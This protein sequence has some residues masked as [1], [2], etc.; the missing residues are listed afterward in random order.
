MKLLAFFMLLGF[1]A[2]HATISA[3]EA[4]IDLKM[5]DATLSQVFRNI[6]QLTE[7]MFIYKSEDV[8][9]I[10]HI[11][12]D[13]RQ[14]MVR[15]VL[16]KC[17]ENTGLSFLFKEN[18]IIIQKK[19]TDQ[20][21]KE[22]RIT[23]KVT[24][25]KKEPLPGV[26]VI[27]KGT[28]LG[29]VTDVDGKYTLA[30]P[31][32]NNAL[33]F[34]MI[35]MK[36]KEEVI[37][38]RTQIDVVME[39]EIS[40]L[41]DV[42]VT[43]YYTQAKN[44]FTGA[45][46]T[47]TAEELQM[48]GNQNI[49]TA[50]QNVDP[51]FMKIDNNLAGSNPN[52]VPE[53][54]IRGAGS[55]SGIESEYEGNPNTPVFIVDGFETTAEKVYDMDPYRVASITLLKDAAATAIYGSRASNGVVV[56]TT[57]A[58]ANGKMQVS[59][60]VDASFYIAD[61]SDYN[62]CNAVEKLEIEKLAGMYTS[63]SVNQQLT[64]NKWYNEKL[65]NIERGY[66]TYWL[67]KPL[68]AVAVANKH[69][70]RL[71]GGNDNIRYGIELGYSNTPGVMK[72]SGR[73]RLALGM[74]LQ[75]IYK[76]LTFRNNLTYSNVKAI[77]SPYGSF[78]VYTKRNPYVRYKDDD[79]NYIYKVDEY[80]PIGGG[81]LGKD[82]YNP[83]YNTTLN[84]TDEEKYN[85]VTNNFGVDWSIMDGLR[86][87]GSFS[88]THQNTYK[89][90]FKPAKHTDF[91]D[92]E[93]D[94]FDRRGSYVGSR[95]ENYSYDASLVMTYFY[96]LEKHVINAN[97]GWN[98]QESVT[99]EF[100][101]KTEGFPNENLDYISFATQYEKDG[102]PAGD[103]Y[104]SRLVGFLGNLNYSYDERYLLDLSF[105]EDASSRFGSDKRWAPFWS[106]G[107]GWNLHNEGFLKN[108]TFINRLK[109]RG[110]YG[111]TGS[112][113]YNPY[114]A[115]TTYKYL[116]GERYHHTVG[117]E[118]MALG[119]EKLGWQRTLQQNYGV[120]IDLWDERINFTGNYYI[121]LS[122]DVLTT[123]TLPPSLGFN[124]YMDNLG[125]VK[126][127]GY[128]LNLRVALVKNL[129]K[130][131]YWSVNATA[132][133]NKNKLLKIS[134]ALRAYNDNQDEDTMSGSK[135]KESN[136]PK[137]RY[138]EG[139][140]MN[141]I[142]VNQSL[143]VDPATGN[144]LFQAVNGDIVTTWSTDNYVIGGCTDSDLEGT[145]GTNL[146]WK[147]LQLNVIFRYSYGGQIYNQ[148]L[149]DK[150]Q[151]AALR[152]NV[153]RRVFEERWQKP[154]DRVMFTKLIGGA[155]ANAT[156]VTKPTSRF[157][158]DNNWLELST[159]NLSYEFKMPW[160][161]K[162][163]LKRLKALFY[164]NDVFRVST[165]KQERGIDYPF[166]RNFSIGLQARF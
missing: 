58:P 133:H 45:A 3:Q 25:E 37:G 122:K 127:Y 32:G 139:K 57:N 104:T 59:Y 71:D 148:T 56:I 24:D 38:K 18:V 9:S 145:F 49:L 92:Y 93:D 34:S 22:N 12:V 23:G 4:R 118:V 74:E 26:T 7:Y 146:A 69:S 117:A 136:R 162:I 70:L 44:S 11:N 27:I 8:Q 84:T 144:E 115:M 164:M 151:D 20:E 129:S 153:D 73:R 5:S 132:L 65:A 114:Q 19:T 110:S 161:K 86:L 113:N 53:F 10:Q 63:K 131:L 60:N 124:S 109:I 64:L 82:Y 35:G 89:D 50:L 78:S 43:G 2:C 17:L 101:V 88:F 72:E 75:Y 166:A 119:N 31:V 95:G 21:K 158:E 62:V 90:N 29:T 54:Q 103:E 155:T 28:K 13:V 1:C 87:K 66:D 149:V 138:V 154:G 48:G 157:I 96:Q 68:D 111:L 137:V 150:V 120:D 123:V 102:S 140:S 106:V 14:T 134:N 85:D 52:V 42:V 76:N 112:Q 94:D 143:G 51:S 83:L 125:E 47:I 141:S 16:E 81:G 100:T 107:L 116:T 160:M 77:N 130:Q 159:L 61:L 105:R 39:E 97:L 41:E 142:W 15:D 121:K 152:E 80:V 67:D 55:I 163:G 79:G 128:E 33:V 40:E 147:G 99:R 108:V 91:A 135:S 126:N 6:E 30:V 36:Q 46:R 98:L 156:S 165:V